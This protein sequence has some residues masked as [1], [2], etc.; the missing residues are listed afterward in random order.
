MPGN[1]PCLTR[2]LMQ[3]FM[4]QIN[5]LLLLIQQPAVDTV[6]FI[7]K[8]PTT[9][10]AAFRATL[11]EI[12]EADL[13]LHIVTHPHV[14][15]QAEAV[16]KTLEDIEADQIPSLPVL[17]KIDRLE[18]PEQAQAALDTF[19]DA[20]AVSALR[21]DGIDI[22]LQTVKDKLFAS[23]QFVSVELPYSEGGL[24]SLFHEEGQVESVKNEYEGVT[25]QGRL[26]IRYLTKYK[27]FIV[28]GFLP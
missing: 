15:S 14:L 21:G 18:E 9:L 16:H 22:L 28:D 19:P 13:L 6:G 4:W 20:V 12:A 3:M 26:P 1:Q 11:E 24:I 5:Y 10:V 27:K 25:I 8:L 2:F 23:Y 17:N 7:Q